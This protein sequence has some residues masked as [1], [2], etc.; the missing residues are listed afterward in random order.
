MCAH[1]ALFPT[2]LKIKPCDNPTDIARY[3]GGSAD[4]LK[5]TR[6]GRQI[7]LKTLRSSASADSRT[8]IHV[9][10]S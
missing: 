4:V 7:A 8:T 1:R 9:G 5:Q 10:H 6:S 2:S 3:R